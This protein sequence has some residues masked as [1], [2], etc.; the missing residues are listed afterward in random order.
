MIAEEDGSE[1]SYFMVDNN[2]DRTSPSILMEDMDEGMLAMFGNSDPTSPSLRDDCQSPS[3]GI[4]ARPLTF[5]NVP[6]S[7][8]SMVKVE[9]YTSQAKRA[10]RTARP[11][12]PEPDVLTECEEIATT[13]LRALQAEGYSWMCLKDGSGRSGR[14]ASSSGKGP[15]VRTDDGEQARM[16]HM[17]SIKGKTL[18]EQNNEPDFLLGGGTAPMMYD[19]L[20]RISIKTNAVHSSV[21]DRMKTQGAANQTVRLQHTQSSTWS[22]A[23]VLFAVSYQLHSDWPGGVGSGGG[24]RTFYGARE[25]GAQEEGGGCV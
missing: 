18:E 17:L 2:T 7:S 16:N 1:S 15:G 24:L 4:L 25:T 10:S 14:S 8:S 6:P 21:T 5:T 12:Q 11:A 22:D 3:L 19:R 20:A 13:E 23:C 9:M